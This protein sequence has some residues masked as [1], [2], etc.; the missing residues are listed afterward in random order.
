MLL[1]GMFQLTIGTIIDQHENISTFSVVYNKKTGMLPNTGEIQ[2]FYTGFILSLI[3]L[4]TILIIGKKYIRYKRINIALFLIMGYFFTFCGNVYASDKLN[5]GLDLTLINNIIRIKNVSYPKFEEVDLKKNFSVNSTDDL[6]IAV[7]DYSNKVTNLKLRYSWNTL[8]KKQHIGDSTFLDIGKGNVSSNSPLTTT[9][10]ES[11]G[12][13]ENT[14]VDLISITN[15]DNLS[16]EY[17]VLKDDITLNVDSTADVGT[18]IICQK[19]Y[20]I[21]DQESD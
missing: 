11:S 5:S 14:T 17:R 4:G 21:Y 9:N 12:I 3:I 15:E 19:V 8:S 18:Y 16:F 2:S 10:F 7:E 1:T 13:P 20:L 6:I